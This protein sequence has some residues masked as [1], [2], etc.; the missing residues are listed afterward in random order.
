MPEL[1]RVRSLAD[2]PRL[3][4]YA[5]LTDVALRRRLEPAGGLYVAEGLKVLRRALEA[6]HSPRSALV[7]DRRADE[8]SRRSAIAARRSSSG[9]GRR[10]RRSPAST[11]TAA[12]S[13]RCTGRRSPTPS[14]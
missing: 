7:L 12:C 1:I 3:A 8:V 9:T 11:C 10:W 2:D 6:G 13:P 4:D 14:S 5:N